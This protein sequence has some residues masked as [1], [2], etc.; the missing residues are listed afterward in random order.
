MISK[1]NNVQEGTTN[2]VQEGSGVIND[3]PEYNPKED[4]VIDGEEMDD[5]IVHKT[6][7]ENFEMNTHSE[8]IT[9]ACKDIL[10]KNSK[11]RRHKIKKEYFDSIAANKVSTKSLVPDLTD[12]YMCVKQDQSRKS[13]VPTENW[14]Q[15]L[16]NTHF[17]HWCTVPEGEAPKS[18]AEIVEEVLKTEV[19]Q[20]T[21]LR[22]VGLRSSRYNSGK[23]TAIVAAHVRDL[24]KKLERS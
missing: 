21:F 10:Q 13:R 9:T 16:H 14:F 12:G 7:K 20:S 23:A 6:D 11:N 1:T 19:K 17:C 2:E 24:E 5:V 3:D 18:D 4:E 15:A 22:N 8:T